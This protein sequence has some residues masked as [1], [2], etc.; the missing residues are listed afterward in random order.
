MILYKQKPKIS[1]IALSQVGIKEI[2][3]KQHNKEVLKY[4]EEIGFDWIKDDETAWCSAFVN[5]VC[6]KAGLDRSKKLNARSWLSIGK[7]TTKPKQWDIVIFWRG[8]KTSWKGHVAFFIRKTPNWIYVYG[9][10]QNNKVG[11]KAYPK[12][13]LLEYRRL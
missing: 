11:I 6:M 8:S 13:R 10:N 2:V 12:S 3:G 9:G 4:F 1:E 5:W 7:I